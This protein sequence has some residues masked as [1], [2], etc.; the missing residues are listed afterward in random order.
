M[1]V[2][3]VLFLL[4]LTEVSVIAEFFLRFG[5]LE[6]PRFVGPLRYGRFVVLLIEGSDHILLEVINREVIKR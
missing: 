2:V 4:V 5:H 6:V 1:V 3:R